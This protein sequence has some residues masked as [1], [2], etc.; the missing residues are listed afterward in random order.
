M[1]SFAR[2]LFAGFRHP[3]RRVVSARL[4]SEPSRPADRRF[5]RR[6]DH[7]VPLGMG[8]IVKTL[9]RAIPAAPHAPTGIHHSRPRGVVTYSGQR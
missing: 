6:A 8:S 5:S 3:M 1:G 9:M 4:C 2:F 7:H